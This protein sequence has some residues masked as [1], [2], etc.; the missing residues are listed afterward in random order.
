MRSCCEREVYG[1]SCSVEW[2]II[3]KIL[4]TQAS[5]F[6]P[7]RTSD[8]EKGQENTCIAAMTMAYRTIK[9]ENVKKLEIQLG[10]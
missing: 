4:I 7:P 9:G 10:N 2:P 6:I 1:A 8:E 5:L 3:C